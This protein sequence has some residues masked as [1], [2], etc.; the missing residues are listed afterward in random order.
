MAEQ[1]K[2]RVNAL[3]ERLP[4]R[5]RGFVIIRN[6]IMPRNGGAE[7][8]LRAPR[9]VCAPGLDDRTEKSNA[10]AHVLEIA[11]VGVESEMQLPAQERL[12]LWDEGGEAR[13]VPC[14]NDEVIHIA[15]VVAH[16][17]GVLDKVIEGVQIEV[18]KHL[19]GEV[20]I[21]NPRPFGAWKRLTKATHG[22]GLYAP[23][24]IS[25]CNLTRRASCPSRR[26]S[27]AVMHRLG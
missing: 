16:A 17:H 14:D 20:A 27:R 7:V 24:L 6:P 13:A 25:S 4:L 22:R 26:P 11:L 21:G 23:E 12:N 8:A 9:G 1:S 15:P 10:V 5:V 18:R 3:S 19:T 2:G